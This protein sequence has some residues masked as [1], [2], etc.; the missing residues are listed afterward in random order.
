MGDQ[1]SAMR[2]ICFFTFRHVAKLFLLVVTLA[3]VFDGKLLREA[4]TMVTY[5]MCSELTIVP[6]FAE[7]ATLCQQLVASSL[8]ADAIYQSDEPMTSHKPKHCRLP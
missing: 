5:R 2:R 1:F 4:F 3:L 8:A 7:T 6:A